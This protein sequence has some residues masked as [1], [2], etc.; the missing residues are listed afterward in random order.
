MS[1]EDLGVINSQPVENTAA[2]E[3]APEKML[4]QSEVNALVGAAKAK[5][6]EIARRELEA[7]M[8]QRAPVIDEEAI[9]KRAQ[10][11]MKKQLEQERQSVI[12]E[13]ERKNAEEL[14][15]VYRNKMSS[16]K[17]IYPD[18]EE[19]VA[20]FDPS[21][22]LNLTILAAQMDGLPEIMYEINKNPSKLVNLDYLSKTDTNR[23]RKEME[24]LVK[25]VRANEQAAKTQVKT[26]SPLKQLKPSIIA[27]SDTGKKTISDLRKMDFLRV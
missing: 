4:S 9:I 20:D 16:G 21:K 14:A 11:A 23:A 22:Y 19:V 8:R 3:S 12:E 27:G 6:A 25:S 1:N 7:E 26:H 13:Q 24:K 17:E 2:P 5:A 15:N 10:E 18:F